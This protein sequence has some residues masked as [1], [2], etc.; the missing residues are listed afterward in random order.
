MT[1]ATNTTTALPTKIFC[2]I[3]DS[4]DE[5]PFEATH[6]YFQEGNRWMAVVGEWEPVDRW[7]EDFEGT[8]P[9][10][11]TLPIDQVPTSG[12]LIF[13]DEGGAYHE[14]VVG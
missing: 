9:E 8:L 4:L 11:T 2:P 10:V 1:T 12:T 14:L 6:W 5:F 3:Y 13:A 7:F